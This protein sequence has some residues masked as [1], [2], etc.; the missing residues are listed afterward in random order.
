MITLGGED[1]DNITL[2]LLKII[3]KHYE[4]KKIY[5][6]LG[7]FHP[8]KNKVY[9]FAESNLKNFEIVNSQRI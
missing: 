3:R 2:L 4:S 8:N 6:V 5:I 9:S 7:P 1:P